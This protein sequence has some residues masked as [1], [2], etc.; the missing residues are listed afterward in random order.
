MEQLLVFRRE[1]FTHIVSRCSMYYVLCDWSRMVLR[2]TG[3]KLF[4]CTRPI[5]GS[6]RTYYIAFLIYGDTYISENRKGL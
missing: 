5:N 6:M 4:A 3:G 2:L 1:R